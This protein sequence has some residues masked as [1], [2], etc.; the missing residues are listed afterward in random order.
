MPGLVWRPKG[1]FAREDDVIDGEFSRDEEQSTPQAESS[2]DKS[3]YKSVIAL[4][5][6]AS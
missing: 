1:K 2:V 4:A 3:T 6:H 5:A